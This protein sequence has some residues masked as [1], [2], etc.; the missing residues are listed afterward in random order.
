MPLHPSPSHGSDDWLSP[1]SSAN[2]CGRRAGSRSRPC[3]DRARTPL[4]S[5]P[6]E[7]SDLST[8]LRGF[9]LRGPRTVRLRQRGRPR[10]QDAAGDRLQFTSVRTSF[11]TVRR[12]VRSVPLSVL[13]PP[14]PLLKRIKYACRAARPLRRAARCFRTVSRRI[15]VRSRRLLADSSLELNQRRSGARLPGPHKGRRRSLILQSHTPE[16]C[17]RPIPDRRG[18]P[19][20]FPTAVVALVPS[21]L[22]AFVV[23]PG[24][25]A[26]RD[27][28]TRTAPAPARSSCT[29]SP[30]PARRSG[31][32]G[33]RGWL[34]WSWSSRCRGRSRSCR[35]C[36]R[37][38][39]GGPGTSRT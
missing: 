2:S 15:F 8:L 1:S 30:T 6:V 24:R 33:R 10:G 12:C 4:P 37:C 22:R 31:R 26:R 20:G 25:R 29:S 18:P 34:R 27:Q 11:Q 3:D 7:T 21:C 36:L 19:S 14:P 5:S 13:Q 9:S 28:L 32:F 38:R 17:F 16:R 39:R 35:R 23:K